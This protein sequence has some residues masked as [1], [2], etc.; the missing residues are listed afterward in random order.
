M[1]RSTKLINKNSFLGIFYGL[2]LPVGMK[3]KA[4]FTLSSSGSI[5]EKM[6]N[7]RCANYKK[8]LSQDTANY[9]FTQSSVS[10]LESEIEK[11]YELRRVSKVRRCSL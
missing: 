10:A 6:L 4:S 2:D 1:N 9:K 11:N 5:Q 7:K 8:L 3:L